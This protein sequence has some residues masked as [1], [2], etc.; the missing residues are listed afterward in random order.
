MKK[1]EHPALILM[2]GLATLLALCAS[3]VQAEQVQNLQDSGAEAAVADE[4]PACATQMDSDIPSLFAKDVLTTLS[5]S[6]TQAT[7]SSFDVIMMG[8]FCGQNCDT[9]FDCVDFCLPCSASCE[10]D[11]CPFVESD[12]DSTCVCTCH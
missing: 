6:V 12:A 1:I 4:I 8:S 10:M 5:T 11:A 2:V 7:A 9:T 3:T